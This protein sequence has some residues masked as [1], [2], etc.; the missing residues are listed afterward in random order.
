[1]KGL[2][3]TIKKILEEGLL[4]N[5]LPKLEKH[6]I[7]LIENNNKDELSNSDIEE[8]IYQRFLEKKK[9]IEE[10]DLKLKTP[11]N[12]NYLGEYID[13][14]ISRHEIDSAE[15]LNEVK[16]DRDTFKKF[17]KNAIDLTIIDINKLVKLCIYFKI[18]LSVTL[19]LLRKSLKLFKINPTPTNAMARYS[20]RDGKE[21]RSISM[22]KGLNELI[23]KASEQTPFKS[24][25][26]VS[27]N[28]DV[29]QFLLKFEEEYKNVSS[30]R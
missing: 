14:L 29:K 24:E 18:K 25:E 5:K 21:E 30:L 8:K 13:L 23:I 16:I 10:M 26:K 15:L 28:I 17:L 6:I 4:E 12:F 27:T 11:E 2:K 9:Y 3:K 20:Y 7:E 22:K 1:M 19:D